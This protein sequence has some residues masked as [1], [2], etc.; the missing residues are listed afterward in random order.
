M[1]CISA[2]LL[3]DYRGDVLNNGQ[4]S[5]IAGAPRWL[6][7]LS[8]ALVMSMAGALGIVRATNSQLENVNRVVIAKEVLSP[9]SDGVE[10][11]LLVGSDS[12]ATAH[13]DD[14][15]YAVVG[16]EAASP[17]MRSDTMIVVSYN[18][19]T[20]SVAT[21]S[22]PRDLWVQ[23]G[24]TSSHNKINA[25]YHKGADV[26]IRS[27]QR[28]L[29]IPIHHY[30]DVNFSGFKK[31]VDA[32]G[33]VHICVAHASRDKATGFYIGKKACKL[34]NGQEALRYARSRHFEEKI[35][36]EWVTDATG[37]VGRG[38]R[39][40]AFIAAL[41]KDAAKYVI[42]HPLRAHTVMDAMTSA[43]S[44]DQNMSLLDLAHKLRPL[45]DGTSKS[46][47]LPVDS[48]MNNGTFVFRLNRDSQPVLAYFAGLS[49]VAPEK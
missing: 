15:D 43:V 16:S 48:D 47:A 21:M 45:G 7:V 8:V 26:L 4:L 3:T 40:R 11:Y 33:G 12:R 38:A 27:V 18:T 39:Q 23:I 22:I 20:S 29:N 19:K 31:I 36:G 14:P 46:Y 24:D 35:D 6:F 10:N 42:E 5:R 1:W 13:P 37:D 44:V 2:L 17:G 25:A 9:A 34:Q 49:P 28:A 30:I 41:V 32:I